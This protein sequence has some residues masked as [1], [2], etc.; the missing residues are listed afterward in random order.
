M[1]KLYNEECASTMQKLEGAV[2]LVFTSP[3]Y[4]MTP[5]KGGT[6]DVG[7]YDVFRDW[8]SEEEYLQF[9][10]ET[11]RG[12]EKVL[13]PNRVVLYNFSYSIENPALP[14][15]LVTQVQEQTDFTLVDTI[16]W[17]KKS[18]LPFPANKRR[19]SRNWEF[20]FVFCRKNEIDTFDTY[21]P[22]SSISEKTG[23]TYYQTFYNFVEARNNDG[24]CPYNKATFSSELCE[25]LMPIYCPEGG[26][27]YDPFMGTG[28]TAVACK[29]LGL[30]C[31]GSEISEAQVGYA[32][33]RLAEE[34]GDAEESYLAEQ[35]QEVW[36]L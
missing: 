11:F 21:R 36:M 8:L 2:D 13:K 20:V 19:L 29:R 3:P 23:Q 9:T 27:V 14:Y 32:A 28:T 26:T 24:V 18:G 17:K 35:E 22:V 34:F 10:V 5:R 15:K 7:R 1:I 31:Y 12:F 33:Q 25:K 6:S 30:N 4:N 16:V